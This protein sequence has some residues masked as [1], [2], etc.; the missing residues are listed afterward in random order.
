MFDG[1]SSRITDAFVAVDHLT[2]FCGMKMSEAISD[3]DAYIRL[4][5]GVFDRILQSTGS[6]MEKVQNC[7]FNLLANMYI[8]LAYYRLVVSCNDYKTEICTNALLM[9]P[10]MTGR[11]YILY[12]F[13]YHNQILRT[14]C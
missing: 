11:G 5:D 12:S 8:I 2:D 9:S 6:E 14:L 7:V 3:M 4:T 10:V 1:Y 13:L